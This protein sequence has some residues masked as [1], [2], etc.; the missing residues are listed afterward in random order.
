MSS[1]SVSL[2]NSTS[3]SKALP[4]LSL[5]RDGQALRL[6]AFRGVV[7]AELPVFQQVTVVGLENQTVAE[8]QRA[9]AVILEITDGIDRPVKLALAYQLASY[10][11]CFALFPVPSARALFPP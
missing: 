3:H 9:F 7:Q 11:R 1:V 8:L 4:K 10:L 5:H 2:L 6:I